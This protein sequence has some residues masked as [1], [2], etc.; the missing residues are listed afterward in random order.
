MGIF[1]VVI[2]TH[3]FRYFFYLWYLRLCSSALVTK[4]LPRRWHII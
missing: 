3:W 4:N 2:M 1:F